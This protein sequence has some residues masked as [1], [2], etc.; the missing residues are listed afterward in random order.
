MG[1]AFLLVFAAKTNAQAF[2]ALGNYDFK[3]FLG[4]WQWS[5]E[6]PGLMG[7]IAMV[8][9]KLLLLAAVAIFFSVF[10]SMTVNFFLSS[11][12]FIVG[13]LSSVTESMA[14]SPKTAAVLTSLAFHACRTSGLRYPESAHPSG[15]PAGGHR[16]TC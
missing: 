5:S 3:G 13:N 10:M 2:T 1:A 11:A 8:Y 12:V 16:D 15:R 14:S 4:L 9:M 7:G 6:I